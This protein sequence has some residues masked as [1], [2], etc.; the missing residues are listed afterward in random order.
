[1][2]FA[3]HCYFLALMKNLYNSRFPPMF[4]YA[5]ILNLKVFFFLV[6]AEGLVFTWLCMYVFWLVNQ[7]LCGLWKHLYQ[8]NLF[9]VCLIQ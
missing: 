4:H 1:M 3:M 2:L 7:H 5:S 9:L 6:P 8:S